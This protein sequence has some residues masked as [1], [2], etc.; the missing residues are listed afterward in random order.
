MEH[1]YCH[2]H[3]CN[4]LLSNLPSYPGLFNPMPSCC[5]PPPSFRPSAPSPFPLPSPTVPFTPPHPALSPL[6]F[7]PKPAA[8]TPICLYC[9]SV[10]RTLLLLPPDYHYTPCQPQPFSH[11]HLHIHP[12][13]LLSPLGLPHLLQHHCD[14]VPSPPEFPTLQ[15]IVCH[16]CVSSPTSPTHMHTHPHSPLLQA[17]IPVPYPRIYPQF[18]GLC[19]HPNTYYLP[20]TLSPSI[21]PP[22]HTPNLS[23][24]LLDIFQTKS[25]MA[26]RR[27]S[28][29]SW[30]LDPLPSLPILFTFIVL[31]TLATH[32][33]PCLSSNITLEHLWPSITS[34]ASKTLFSSLLSTTS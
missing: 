32:P 17:T 31:I 16:V 19:C 27:V 18:L 3:Y 33:T 10:P 2:R 13:P 4:P 12:S 1:R 14:P 7:A 26:L 9:Q 24:T 23:S 30:L 8:T 22:G 29:T 34:T 11:L 25:L 15:H 20:P 5:I 28:I 21:H 6:L